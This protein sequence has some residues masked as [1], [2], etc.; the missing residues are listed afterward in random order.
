[1][2]NAGSLTVDIFV[3]ARLSPER[4][5]AVTG[6]LT[7]LGASVR[8]KVLPPRRTADDLQWIVLAALPLQAFLS[9]I[10][11]KIA[12]DAYKGLQNA[13]RK[14]RGPDAA[15]KTPATRPMIL[16]DTASGLRVILDHDLPAD[17]YQQL[18]NLDL[19]RFQIGPVHYDRTQQ[20]WRSE[21]DEAA[22]RPSSPGTTTEREG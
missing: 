22:R 14:L 10:G 12:D 3:D 13:V 20:R 15:A 11:G 9:S 16:Q 4:E 7:A 17:G 8:V 2:T 5:Q 6:A 21:L 1:M 19:A 18:L